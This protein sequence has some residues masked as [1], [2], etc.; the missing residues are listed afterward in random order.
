VQADAAFSSTYLLLKL[1]LQPVPP[2]K[3]PCSPEGHFPTHSYLAVRATST[4]L[5]G[6]R[7]PPA[8]VLVRRPEDPIGLVALDQVEQAAKLSQPAALVTRAGLQSTT[9]SVQLTSRVRQGTP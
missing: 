6:G 9:P 8:G 1:Q 3:A 2:A 5:M 4:R 7:P